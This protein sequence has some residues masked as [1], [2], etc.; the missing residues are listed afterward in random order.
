MYREKRSLTEVL[1]PIR[2]M[3]GVYYI[4]NVVGVPPALIFVPPT[5]I[6]PQAI[7]ADQQTWP[8]LKM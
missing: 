2:I 5:S 8:D 4:A 3:D 7:K 1:M 6:L